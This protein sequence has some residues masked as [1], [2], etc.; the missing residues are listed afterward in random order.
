M[1]RAP[2]AGKSAV[3]IRTVAQRAGVSA[4]TVSNVLNGRQVAPETRDAVLRAVRDLNYTPNAAAKQLATA[5]ILT[6]GMLHGEMEESFLSR[7]MVGASDAA[8]R[9]GAQIVMARVDAFDA[10][11]ILEAIA[12]L[13]QGGA[14]GVLLPG[15]FAERILGRPELERIGLPMIVIAPGE[16]ILG[17]PS[18]RIDET[19]AARA[20]TTLLIEGGAERIGFL[21][22]PAVVTDARRRGYL[23]ALRARGRACVAELIVVGAVD[24]PGNVE[25][26]GRLLDQRP[27]PD[28]IFAWND[29]LAACA[30]IAAHR[31][32]LDVPNDVAI[33]GFDDSSIAGKVWPALTSVRQPIAEMAAR[34]LENLVAYIRGGAAIGP[35]CTY[36][37]Y[38]LIERGST[39]SD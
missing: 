26:A 36:F 35:G 5:A 30:L 38:T 28:A 23:D 27:R 6:I 19:A 21:D 2:R 22:G 7:M 14:K 1:K 13:Q 16:E 20:M 4:M 9:T 29:D 8:A 39:G 10:G 33:A 17:I 11:S 31:R 37:D 12:R 32:G 25:A 24:I 18:I 3:T 34:G 15:P